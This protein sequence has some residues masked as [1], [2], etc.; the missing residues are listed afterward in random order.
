MRHHVDNGWC[1]APIK[2]EAMKQHNA[3][4]AWDEEEQQ[5]LEVVYGKSYTQ[6]MGNGEGEL[7]DENYRK[8]DRVMTMAI[9]WILESVGFK[10]VR[11]ET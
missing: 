11:D 5:N 10:M 9:P 6:K 4:V 7:L 8:L 3:L 2:N 1:Y